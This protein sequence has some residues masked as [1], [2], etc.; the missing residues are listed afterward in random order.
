MTERGVAPARLPRKQTSGTPRAAVR[1]NYVG[2]PFSG[3]DAGRR[4][5]GGSRP[6][7]VGR[8]AL[9][10]SPEA[11][12]PGCKVAAMERREA[13]VPRTWAR[14]APRFWCGDVWMR[15]SVKFQYRGNTEVVHR[16]SEHIFIR[17]LEFREAS[18][19]AS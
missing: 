14:A 8:N 13:R 2:L 3:L 4:N 6:D 7:Q 1:P 9:H 11:T 12:A 17:G 10:P 18:V 5:G 16:H 19:G 15:R